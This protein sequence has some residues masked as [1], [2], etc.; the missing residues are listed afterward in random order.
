MGGSCT[1]LLGSA[2]LFCDFTS[3]HVSSIDPSSPIARP[4][5]PE[6]RQTIAPMTDS[7]ELRTS[8]KSLEDIEEIDTILQEFGKW[9]Q[10]AKFEP[11]KTEKQENCADPGLPAAAKR[12]LDPSVF[13]VAGPIDRA[14]TQAN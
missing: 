8:P 2:S 6:A 11:M 14:C 13:K 10:K 5:S 9:L 3:P 12:L 7:D 4:I 1:V